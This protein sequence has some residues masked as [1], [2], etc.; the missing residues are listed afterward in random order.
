MDEHFH[1]VLGPRGIYLPDEEQVCATR[2]EA[3]DVARW[4]AAE[5]R[6][7]G[8]RVFGS[9]ARGYY[10]VGKFHCI[11]I[12]DCVEEHCLDELDE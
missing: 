9:A 6:Q 7:D 3:E 8:E 11:E 12:T 2:D 1:V 4:I 5:Q 10:W